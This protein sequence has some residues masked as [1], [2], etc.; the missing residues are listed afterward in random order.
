MWASLALATAM[1]LTPAQAGGLQCTNVRLTHGP[2][3]PERKDSKE[4]KILPGELLVVSFDLVGLKVKDNGQAR[5][6]MA[7]ELLQ[8]DKAGKE[9]SVFSKAPNPLETTLSLG[10]DRVPN[11]ANAVIGTD[12]A[13]GDYVMKVTINDLE[14]KTKT[15][16][17]QKFEVVK[18]QLGFV[19]VGLVN[20]AG[21]PAP[22][23]AVPG[24]TLFLHYSLVG[25]E[26]VEKKNAADC[27]LEISI[28]D[29]A[30]GKPTLKPIAGKLKDIDKK[31]EQFVPFDPI[32]ILLNR[33]GKFSI[34]LKVTDNLSKKTAEQTFPLAVVDLNK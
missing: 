6:D 30:T 26:L 29:D 28:I 18:P 34:N 15:L 24:Q 19:R 23:L 8:I 27:A 31:F 3:G 13:P 7:L 11:F 4:P 17:T 32:P 10:G 25:F 16:L 33:S 20:E 1:T 5:F 9:K 12:T 2:L 21:Q 14:A 22:P